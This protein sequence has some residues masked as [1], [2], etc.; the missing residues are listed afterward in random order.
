MYPYPSEETC[1]HIV[2]ACAV[3]TGTHTCTSCNRKFNSKSEL[4]EHQKQGCNGDPFR[5]NYKTSRHIREHN[6]K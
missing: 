5:N 3:T 4:K 1:V 6:F 2:N